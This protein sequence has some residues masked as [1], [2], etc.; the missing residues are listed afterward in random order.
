MHKKLALLLLPFLWMACSEDSDSSDHGVAVVEEA[1]TLSI[2]DSVL[3]RDS[4]VIR[5]SVLVRDSVVI[6]DSIVVHDSVAVRDSVSIRDSVVVRDSVAIKDSVEISVQFRDSVEV[7]DVEFY[8]GP[9]AT[10]HSDVV[11]SVTINGTER[12]FVCDKMTLL[13]RVA[14]TVDMT[15]FYVKTSNVLDF[16]DVA[17]LYQDLAEDEKLVLILRH[18]ERGDDYS[19]KGPLNGNGFKQAE[20]LGVSLVGAE[21]FYYAGTHVVRSQ[22]TCEYI[23]KGR[24]D[25]SFV[26]D[27]VDEL[28]SG[29]FEK[30]PD[31]VSTYAANEKGG[32]ENWKVITR[33][34]YE[35]AYADAFYAMDL[36]FSQL[37]EDVVLPKFNDSGKRVGVFISHDTELIPMVAYVSQGNIDLRFHE[38]TKFT[39]WINYLA[40]IAVVIRA[41]GTQVYYAAKGLEKGT[42]E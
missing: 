40:G 25:E 4:L 7:H 16:V 15:N 21:S 8:L 33:F 36:R 35:G 24:N 20:S 34:A 41:D 18:A 38:T 5:D 14:T 13:W 1:D 9:C 39:Q 23:A 27:T 12:S 28:A 11:K 30:D 19:S 17:T 22:Q 32:W 42:M 31:A 29:W 3:I 37:M 26:P 2:E 10:E 6:R